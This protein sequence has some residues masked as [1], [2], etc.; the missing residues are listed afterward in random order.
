[1]LGLEAHADEAGS[2]MAEARHAGDHAERQWRGE[3]A[4][5]VEDGVEHAVGEDLHSLGFAHGGFTIVLNGAEIVYGGTA[6]EEAL[7]EYVGGGDC[8]LHERC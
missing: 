5:A 3:G 8:V 7:G 2:E 1:M 4:A 6:G